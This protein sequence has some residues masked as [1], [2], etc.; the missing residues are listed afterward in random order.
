M[1]DVLISIYTSFVS[2]LCTG[3]CE[4]FAR[5][6]VIFLY[7]RLFSIKRWM[8]WSLKIVASLSITS[9]LVLI[10][11]SIFHCKPI[12]AAFDA[13]IHGECLDSQLAFLLYE[14]SNLVLDLVVAFLPV[15]VIWRLHLPLRE[16]LGVCGIFLTGSL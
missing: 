11:V 3:A 5:L 15:R 13:S 2:V 1:D 7:Y 4:T 14:L 6:S 8:G 16:R 9:L 12:A 10:I